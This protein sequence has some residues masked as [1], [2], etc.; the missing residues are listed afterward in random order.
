MAV[1]Q[2]KGSWWVDFRCEYVRYRKRSPENSRAGAQAYEALLR[3]R[4]AR[5]EPLD[6]KKHAADKAETFERFAQAWLTGYV[7]TNN[8][9][10]EQHNKRV[11]LRSSLIPFFGR[12]RLD[13]IGVRDIELFKA[14]ERQKGNSNKTINN[15]LIMLRKCLATASEWGELKN[16]LPAIKKLSSPQ[17]KTDVL[18][19]DEAERLL[20]NAEGTVREMIL[21][22][23]RTG[24]RQG[25]IRG[26]Q[27]EAIDWDNRFLTVRHTLCDYSKSL[28]SP[29]SNR[30]RYIPLADD[31]FDV[32]CA[33][34]ASTGYV[35]TDRLGRPFTKD[36]HLDQ[37]KKVQKR[38]GLRNFG[39]HT[40]RH[41]FATHL[42]A[43][44]PLRT[45]QELL[46]HSTITMTMR[47]SHVSAENLRAAI[48]LLSAA[49]PPTMGSRWATD[50]Q[51]PE[52]V[53]NAG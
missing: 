45:V 2:I 31:L 47:Y 35:F 19:K 3:R 39:W 13:E 38:A 53:A 14:H 50:V 52:N 12:M 36:Y 25:E 41:T 30:E 27:W 46:G 11:V 20:A 49:Q 28:A 9:P 32:L 1:R 4:L 17:S 16:A 18:S 22:A 42:S 44:V 29:K 10:A 43:K 37:L 48:D 23:L 7:E 34:R 5:G 21:M 33:R 15:K 51:H 24:M 40:L 8:K 6:E 26:L